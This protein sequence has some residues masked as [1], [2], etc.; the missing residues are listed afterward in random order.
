[1]KVNLLRSPKALTHFLL[2]TH[3]KQLNYNMKQLPSIH[4]FTTT[5]LQI[6]ALEKTHEILGG[7]KESHNNKLQFSTMAHLFSA[8]CSQGR[9]CTRNRLIRVIT[10]CTYLHGPP[11]FSR[12]T[13][14]SQEKYLAPLT[15]HITRLKLNRW[16]NLLQNYTLQRRGCYTWKQDH[17]CCPVC[18]YASIEAHASFP[19]GLSLPSKFQCKS[20]LVQWK[21]CT[22]VKT[23]RFREHCLYRAQPSSLAVFLSSVL[24]SRWHS[25]SAIGTF[26][27]LGT[28]PI[29]VE[30]HLQ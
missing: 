16:L 26:T 4:S 11:S 13:L 12:W 6:A 7:G 14:I 29:T 23:N 30:K 10:E 27:A 8:L 19:L 17:S 21:E 5:G 9:R 20:H 25:L 24:L 1:M 18:S 3:I 2:K 22:L 28:L 15:Q